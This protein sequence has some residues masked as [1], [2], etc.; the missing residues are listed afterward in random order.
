MYTDY[1]TDEEESKPDRA[2][3]MMGIVATESGKLN[4]RKR[5]STQSEILGKIPKG[6]MITI[7]GAEG[8]WYS[9][10]YNGMRGYVSSEY[11]CASYEAY[12]PTYMVTFTVVDK[13]MLEE[14]TALLKEKAIFFE[15]R[16]AAD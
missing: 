14:L 12:E 16:E 3:P 1:D 6:E 9:V 2:Y 8:T 11:V 7:T 10:E 13:T 5:P 4:L 15:V